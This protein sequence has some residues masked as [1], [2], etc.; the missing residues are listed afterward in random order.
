MA[1]NRL[2]NLPIG[3][4]LALVASLALLL[5]IPAA[6]PADDQL[7]ANAARLEN[8]SAEQK[9]ELSRKR[10]RF[11][12]LNT[13]EQHR[14]RSLHASIASDPGKDELLDTATRYS[15][16]LSNLDSAE[17]SALLDI[18]DP[19][20]RIERI[21]EIMHQQEDRRFR[22]YFANLS[23]EDRETIHRWL[24]EFVAARAAEIRDK[25]PQHARERIDEAKDS[26]G[27]R[28]ELF[29]SWQR[30]L[31]PSNLPYPGQQDLSE[32][33]KRLSAETQKALENTVASDLSKEP[34]NQRT[35]E[36]RQELQRA[37]MEELMRIAL[38]SRFF[39]QISHEDL[40]KFYATMKSDDPRRKQLEGKEGEDLRREL[41][42]MYN[43]EHSQGRGPPSGG[44]GFGPPGWGSPPP[45]G[46]REGDR[47]PK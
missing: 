9:E 31:R 1:C 32:L 30:W 16:W 21:K 25:L 12:E 28:R 11:D 10:L 5:S 47:D 34:E 20:K 17:R 38:Y 14:L 35:A 15:R 33:L 6:L 29:F 40:L 2:C 3:T 42:R 7:A 27:R 24:G 23:P 37:R 26:D 39:P 45:R 44:R 8:M 18:K 19:Q 13:A 22:Q 43:Y 46:P 41:Q 36:R 4:R